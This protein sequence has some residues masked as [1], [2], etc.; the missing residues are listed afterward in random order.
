MSG[1]AAGGFAEG[2]AV[3]RLGLPPAAGSSPDTPCR[4]VHCILSIAALS[5]QRRAAC[6][7]GR[8]EAARRPRGGR[9]A[10][11]RQLP[12]PCP[13]LEGVVLL[14]KREGA[15]I[16]VLHMPRPVVAHACG[17]RG[18]Q[19][20]RGEGGGARRTAV[21][22]LQRQLCI[23]LLQPQTGMD[24]P[25][26]STPRAESNCASICS[27]PA[28]TGW[29]PAPR[30]GCLG[31]TPRDLAAPHAL[32]A[33]ARGAPDSA[34][35]WLWC[36]GPTTGAC[37]CSTGR[38]NI[39]CRDTAAAP[40]RAREERGWP[41]IGSHTAGRLGGSSTHKPAVCMVGA[42]DQG[43]RAAFLISWRLHQ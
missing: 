43:H 28:G 23:P 12:V 5:G 16:G 8:R 19:G 10:A 18:K 22:P 39:T 29:A 33:P 24:A 7:I 4:P 14:V 17:P 36:S 25:D 34:C 3:P 38:L 30:C 21:G 2:A 37:I 41:Q 35:F 13:P 32:A 42:S 1:R 6:W 9:P 31:C 26:S 27:M 40:G 11:A 15:Q 20:G